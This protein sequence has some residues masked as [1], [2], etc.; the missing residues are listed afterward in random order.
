MRRHS[1]GKTILSCLTLKKAEHLRQY[2]T[3]TLLHQSGH[4]F[5]TDGV[6]LRKQSITPQQRLHLGHPRDAV[7]GLRYLCD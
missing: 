2:C 4:I 6:G 7:A 3:I 5:N 1:R